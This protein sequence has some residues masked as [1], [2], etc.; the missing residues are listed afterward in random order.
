MSELLNNN[1]YK[2]WLVDDSTTPNKSGGCSQQPTD[3]TLLGFGQTNYR[4][5]GKRQMRKRFY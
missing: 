2:N 5:A 4:K 3:S 1:D